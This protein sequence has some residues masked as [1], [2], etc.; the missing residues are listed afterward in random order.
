MSFGDA[1]AHLV[2]LEKERRVELEKSAETI[3]CGLQLR[4]PETKS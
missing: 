1:L 3:L 4:P 2:S